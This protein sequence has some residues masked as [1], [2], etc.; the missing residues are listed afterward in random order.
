MRGKKILSAGLIALMMV[1]G[2][3]L[4]ACTWGEYKGADT[5]GGKWVL[6]LSLGQQAQLKLNGFI[7]LR[8]TYEKKG[9]TIYLTI[10][11]DLTSN[12]L[13]GYII[14]GEKK[15]KKIT[16]TF[17]ALLAGIFNET[18]VVFGKA[19]DGDGTATADI[20]FDDDDAEEEFEAADDA[21]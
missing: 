19:V 6:T 18:E 8:G 14:K 9:S 2:L 7:C 15:G 10:V 4:A 17:S 16:L 12:N 13:E 20:E 21:E 11:D 5:S 1:A 3:V